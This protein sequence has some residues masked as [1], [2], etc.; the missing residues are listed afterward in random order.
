MQKKLIALAVAGLGLTGAAY[1][2]SNVTVYGVIDNTFENV[3]ANNFQ[4]ANRVTA[5]SS[6]LGF[7]GEESLGNGLKAKFLFES[8]LNSD[9]TVAN[10]ATGATTATGVFGTASRDAWVSLSSDVA[11]EVRLGTFNRNTRTLGS[12]VDYAWGYTGSNNVKGIIGAIGANKTGADE[13]IANAVGYF[14]PVIAGGLQLSAIY[15]ANENKATTTPTA[16]A[17]TQNAANNRA[18][19]L[20]AMYNNG[21]IKAGVAYDR[22]Y[23]GRGDAPITGAAASTGNV[24]LVGDQGYVSSLRIG[25]AY[26]FPTATT[27]SALWDKTKLQDNTLNGSGSRNAYEFGVKQDIGAHTIYGTFAKAKEGDFSSVGGAKQY[28]L[29]YGYNFS[30]RTLLKA[31][32]SKMKNDK[33]AG[34]Y[35]FYDGGITGGTGDQRTLGVGIRHS[36]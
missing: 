25:G 27:V 16:A 13:R 36:F 3:K 2:Q 33:S 8:G 17:A 28:V 31:Y 21:P 4:T 11:G 32:Y 6:Y 22:S 29:A 15:G 23:T 20:G 19:D 10:G 14:S 9:G 34:T 12:M 24:T 30:K 35:G 18:W 7:K 1:A 26:T 5:N